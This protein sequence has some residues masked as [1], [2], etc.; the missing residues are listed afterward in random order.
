MNIMPSPAQI[1]MNLTI[2]VYKA[3]EIIKMLH[4]DLKIEQAQPFCLTLT[5]YGSM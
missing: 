2:G 3:P 1:P 4:E 5:M